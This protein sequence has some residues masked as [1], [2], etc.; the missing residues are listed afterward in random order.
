MKKNKKPKF[1][2]VP[3]PRQ[4]GGPQGARNA[5]Q[6]KRLAVRIK[7]QLNDGGSA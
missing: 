4:T 6:A 1:P 3:L 5:G 7:E 2:R